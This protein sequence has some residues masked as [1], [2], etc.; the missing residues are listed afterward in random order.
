MINQVDMDA[1]A[2]R[3][4]ALEARRD[5]WVAAG[6]GREVA[7]DGLYLIA[8]EDGREVER[9]TFLAGLLDLLGFPQ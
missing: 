7:R 2:A 6:P 3:M 5:A 1:V 8:C 4:S 9:H